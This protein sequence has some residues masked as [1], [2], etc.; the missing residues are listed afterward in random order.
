MFKYKE[1]LVAKVAKFINI[2]HW[3]K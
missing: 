1:K 3:F 2:P